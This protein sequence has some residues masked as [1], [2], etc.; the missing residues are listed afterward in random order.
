MFLTQLALPVTQERPE[1]PSLL[2]LDQWLPYINLHIKQIWQLFRQRQ[3]HLSKR[4]KQ[5][6]LWRHCSSTLR[7][8]AGRDSTEAGLFSFIVGRPMISVC[9]LRPSP[10]TINHACVRIPVLTLLTVSSH[11]ACYRFTSAPDGSF[12]RG[13]PH[14]SPRS[15]SL[16]A[17]G[18]TGPNF[19][20]DPQKGLRPRFPRSRAAAQRAGF[21]TQCSG[22]WLQSGRAAAAGSCRLSLPAHGG[23]GASRAAAAGGPRHVGAGW[24]GVSPADVRP[25]EG[26]GGGSL[27]P[28]LPPHAGSLSGRGWL[29]APRTGN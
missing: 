27:L 13:L 10:I 9:L 24:P 25:G 14:A 20:V 8:C 23:A 7:R 5:T 21:P 4:R 26:G 18:S 6:C 16:T 29:G 11:F 22:H 1:Q 28:P 17:L 2:W 3:T 12:P 15:D 19:E